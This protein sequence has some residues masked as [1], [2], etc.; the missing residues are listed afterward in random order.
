M[1]AMTNNN[2]I[3]ESGERLTFF[4]LFSEKEYKVEIPIIQR[5]YAQGRETASEVRDTFL[6]ALYNYLEENV[7]NRDLDFVYG[8]LLIDND[9]VTKFIPLDGQQRLTTLFLLHWYLANISQ[10]IDTL[11]DVIAVKKIN[12]NNETYYLSKF[13][14]ETRTSSREFCNELISNEINI[15]HLLK[16]DKGKEN[17]LSKT[18]RDS[19]WFYLSWENDPTIQSM[20]VMLDAIHSK[21]SKRA[22]FF[23][24]LIDENKPI[25]TFLFLNLKEFKLTDDLYIKMN[26]RGKPL[27]TFENF[28]AKFEQHIDRLNWDSKTQ[29]R[30]KYNDKEKLTSPRE[31]FSYKIDTEWA[32]LFWNYKNEKSNDNSFDDEL[33]NFIRVVISNHYACNVKDE[34]DENLEFLI[35]TFVAKKRKDYTDDITYFI[36]N[37]NGALTEPAITYLINAFDRI[38]NGTS[39]ISTYLSDNFFYD[40]QEVFKK[41]L[42]HDL[43]LHQRVQF[44]AYIKFLIFNKGNTKGL[45]QWMRVIHNLTENTR[46]DGADE[47]A[48]AIKQIEKLLP[49]SS[50][51]LN[52]LLSDNNK[53]DFFYSTQIQEEKIKAHLIKKSEEWKNAIETTDKHPYFKGQIGFILEFSD[54]LSYYEEYGNSNWKEAENSKYFDS[55]KFY[56]NNATG[57][58]DKNGTSAIKDFLWE[59]A[60]LTKGN[61]LIQAKSSRRNFLSTEHNKRDFSWKRLLR[62]PPK[63]SEDEKEW[64]ERRSFV[65]EVF[66]DERYDSNKL[67][68]SLAKIC[69]SQSDDWRKYFINNP[70]LIRYCKQGFIRFISESDILLYRASQLNHY[71]REMY[72]YDFFLKELANNKDDYKPFSN[73]CHR[74]V[75]GGDN[76]SCAELDGWTYNRRRFK[77]EVCYTHSTNPFEISFYKTKGG[78]GIE[79]YSDELK[80]ILKSLKFKWYDEDDDDWKGYWMSKKTE[81]SAAKVIK[82]FCDEL[83][84]L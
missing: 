28:K 40:E 19:N 9:D 14:Y 35:G 82:N 49:F 4:K 52:F 72:S 74:E 18:I 57:V 56:T 26:A 76:L 45:Y 5:D 59:R 51:I 33:M 6:T 77:I 8:S 36:Y 64:Q 58:F 47:V 48:K 68:I 34:K 61:Y 3:I 11:R 62:L 60:V 27:T 24:R 55:F 71:H 69:K 22:D 53:I 31:Y 54:I 75:K 29:Y 43:T 83:M 30:L 15:Q 81:R 46:I 73:I 44:H 38:T 84:K 63:G 25:I 79:E 2:T 12:E 42:Q 41:V 21:F 16:P 7:P 23:H 70:E 37:R 65:K 1:E 13:T 67:Q 17:N 66:D 20:L 10:N 32:D 80:Q 50:D 78:K 39:M